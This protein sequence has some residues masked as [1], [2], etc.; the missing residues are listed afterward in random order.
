M[1]AFETLSFTHSA[2]TLNFAYCDPLDVKTAADISLSVELSGG[3][4]VP[5]WF[6][7]DSSTG[8]FNFSP[9]TEIFADQTY[10]I[11]V[12]ATTDSV[13]YDEEKTF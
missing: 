4:A 1:K 3:A 12:K 13:L 11:V 8:S 6:N 2:Y 9:V 7:Y 5:A 10:D